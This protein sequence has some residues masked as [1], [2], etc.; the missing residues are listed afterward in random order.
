MLLLYYTHQPIHA[1]AQR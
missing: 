1:V